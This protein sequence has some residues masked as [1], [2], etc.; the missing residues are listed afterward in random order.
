VATTY[1]VLKADRGSDDVFA[2]VRKVEAASAL[3]AIRAVVK[4]EGEEAGGVYAA[5]PERSWVVQAVT[6]TQT[7][8]ISLEDLPTRP[9]LASTLPSVAVGASTAAAT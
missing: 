9:K 1:L 2:P 6:L 3:A 7:T 4:G 8:Q 5:V